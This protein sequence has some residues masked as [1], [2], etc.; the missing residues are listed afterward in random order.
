MPLAYRREIDAAPVMFPTRPRKTGNEPDAIH[1]F[2]RP[3]ER[4]GRRTPVGYQGAAAAA[5]CATL[6]LP[7]NGPRVDASGVGPTGIWL[8]RPSS[9]AG[10]MYGR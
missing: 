3:P 9:R 4:S 5:W 8:G 6:G 1:I 10:A 7:S 2:C